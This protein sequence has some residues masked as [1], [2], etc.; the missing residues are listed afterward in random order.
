LRAHIEH[1][2]RG[3]LVAL[4]VVT[5]AI[6]A[7]I[8]VQNAAALA[9]QWSQDLAFFHQLVHSAA[10]GGPWA[11]PLILEPQGF[12]DMVHTHF[13]L[14]AVVAAYKVIPEQS[15][16][17]IMHSLFACLTIWPAFR[18]GDSVAGG[19][20][21]MLCALALIVFGPFQGVAT[22]DFRPVA[23]FMP[24]L[25]GVWASA[26]RSD[27]KGILLWS[28]VALIGRQEAAYLLGCIG[29]AILFVPWGRARRRDAIILGTIA[30]CA[31]LFFASNK[32]SM[33]FHI[34][35]LA[36]QAWP[37]S[38]ELWTNRLAFGGAF[39]LSG[40]WLGLLAPA[41]LIA[42]LPVLWGLLSTGREWHLLT[43][44]GAHHHAFWLPFVIAA[45]VAGSARIPK[46][47][48]P[49][50]LFVASAFAFPWTTVTQGKPELKVLVEQV[51]HTAKV[52]ADYD[53][54]HALAGRDTLWNIDQ[55][56]MD[57]K[58]WH[59]KGTWPITIED[60]DWIL[61]P[62]NHSLGSRLGDWRIVDATESHVLL[63]RR[64]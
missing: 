36:P 52:A 62:T 5:T 48:G 47:V 60:V 44:P 21:A 8:N 9:P 7:W 11:S 31:W 37:E 38:P 53:T 6:F 63:R 43:G 26:W 14:G 17:L 41:P 10:T 24:G 4:V 57:D 27:W 61:M 25:V 49:V 1:P 46:G 33:F 34:N 40:W 13:V 18:L 58:P 28:A 20:H 55:L 42:M 2:A 54:I 3:L 29:L 12:L 16:L 22:A 32:P 51:P 64:L 23:L 19:R 45:G 50:L 39:L 56:Y 15:V 35:P 30:L 59:W